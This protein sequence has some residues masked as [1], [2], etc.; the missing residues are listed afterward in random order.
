MLRGHRVSLI[1]GLT[2]ALA[3]PLLLAPPGEPRLLG[4]PML[5]AVTQTTARIW[6]R[7]SQPVRARVRY[8]LAWSGARVYESDALPLTAKKDNAGVVK[9]TGLRVKNPDAPGG[10]SSVMT[11]APV[12]ESALSASVT[13]LAK[14]VSD[15][16]GFSE[17]YVTWL[18][19][20]RAG[21]AGVFTIP[22]SEITEVMEQTIN[23]G[24]G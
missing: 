23:Q 19:S 14:E 6:L 22:L 13:K 12:S 11:H 15:L 5:G 3:L 4:S 16:D 20:F 17:G 8:S 9:L 10:F 2:A 7:S 18:S 24:G 21:D 1:V